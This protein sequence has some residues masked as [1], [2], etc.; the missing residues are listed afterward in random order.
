[1]ALVATVTIQASQIDADQ[2][3]YVCAVFPDSGSGW[4]TFWATVKSDGGD[5][6]VFDSAGTTEYPRHVESID[7][8]AKT[9]CFHVKIPGTTSATVNTVF[10]VHADGISN[11]PL[12]IA[13]NGAYNAWNHSN[14][15]GVYV[16]NQEP[17]NSLGDITDWTGKGRDA[18]SFNFTGATDMIDGPHGSKAI[19]FTRALVQYLQVNVNYG[20][21]E[22]LC[23]DVVFRGDTFPVGDSDV[24]GGLPGT[25]WAMGNND[26]NKARIFLPELNSAFAW[27]TTPWY[28][29]SGRWTDTKI[30]QWIDG[31]EV[32]DGARTGYLNSQTSLYIGARNPS[33]RRWDGPVAFFR[34]AFGDQNLESHTAWYRNW[35]APNTF[36]T[37]TDATP[38]GPTGTGALSAPA[39]GLTGAG[40][41]TSPAIS[42][43]GALAAAAAGLAGAGAVFEGVSGEGALT[44]SQAALAASGSVTVPTFTGVGQLT[45]ASA[46]IAGV[47][48]VA[49][50]IGSGA[51]Q[52]SP[53]AL[54]GSGAVTLPSVSGSGALA[55]AAAEV[56]G[57]G[58]AVTTPTGSGSMTA[59]AALLAGHGVY[60]APAGA[61]AGMGALAPTPAEVKGW[62]LARDP[63]SIEDLPD[64]GLLETGMGYSVSGII[65][66]A[67]DLLAARNVDGVG[68][69][70]GIVANAMKA[71]FD[72]ERDAMLR[73]NPFNFAMRRVLLA[74]SS[75]KPAYRFGYAYPLPAGRD[76][77]EYCLRVWVVGDD[78][79]RLD[80][81]I[82]EVAGR[83]L[84]T[85][86]GP[87]LPVRY[88]ARVI[89]PAEW[90]ANAVKAMS[91]RLA[92][93]YA[94]L[95]TGSAA[96][97]QAME[98]LYRQRIESAMAMDAQ[99]GTPEP[100]TENQT[101][102]ESR[103]TNW[104][105]FP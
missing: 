59:P 85:N 23:V 39:A 88:I 70:R 49:T 36:Y 29:M 65:N 47:G 60:T 71:G 12:P 34:F 15:Q 8:G 10:Q 22:P 98:G 46:Q 13:S 32:N 9:G 94:Y 102:V 28:A 33:S 86:Q 90:D 105:N 97:A 93:Q 42:G 83:L 41:V 76:Y 73:E 2:T 50:N 30:T 96:V 20:V 43:S 87:P 63:V 69:S 104:T 1:M 58:M 7:T 6:R 82:W 27:S 25:N 40:S 37:V 77:P 91:A 67:L 53:A 68:D 51:L 38:S 89:N 92:W 75:D 16:M 101:W 81:D 56:A 100:Y 78:E 99:E 35:D 103:S 95:A 26:G 80:T 17:D 5:I 55:A 3:D 31:V 57:A 62:A 21:T 61:I 45:A 79:S 11:E 18:D 72:V 19:H 54:M 24:C 44:A 66:D 14:N 64:T 4:N 84:L 52:A 74:A 48:A